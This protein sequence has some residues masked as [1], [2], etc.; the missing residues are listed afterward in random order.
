VVDNLRR[1]SHCRRLDAFGSGDFARR[2]RHGVQDPVCDL[3][4]K[5]APVALLATAPFVPIASPPLP[6]SPPTPT[7]AFFFAPRADEIFALGLCAPDAT[8][9]G[10]RSF[11]H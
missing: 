1:D 3:A 11:S 10:D 8:V 5:F 6:I 4:E 7:P 2:Q 9:G